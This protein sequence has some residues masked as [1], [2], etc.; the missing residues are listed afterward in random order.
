MKLLFKILMLSLPIL[1]V[2]CVSYGVSGVSNEV[3][4]S[5]GMTIVATN[6]LGNMSIKAGKGFERSFTW[7]GGTR[8]I[9]LKPRKQRWNGSFGLYFPGSGNHWKEHDGITRA[10]VE[11]GY[12]HFNSLDELLTYID[13]FEDKENLVYTDEG[14]FVYWDKRSGAGGTL[15]VLIWQFFINGN[16][17]SNIPGS[18][19]SRISVSQN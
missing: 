11:E 19:N 5:E 15:S 13:R 2:A 3:V 10:V 8:S 17:P 6:D 16:K 12:L 9:I 4:M 1:M 14:L 7:S 18:D